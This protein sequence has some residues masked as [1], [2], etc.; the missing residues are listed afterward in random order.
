M[1]RTGSR[2]LAGLTLI[3]DAGK[4]SVAVAVGG[5]FAGSQMAA[6]AGLL[7]GCR[8][9]F[10]DLAEICWWQGRRHQSCCVCNAGSAAWRA[11]Y[12][13]VDCYRFVIALF[14]ACRALRRA[15]GDDWQLFFCWMMSSPRSLFLR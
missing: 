14:I 4:G 5:H 1:L 3:F 13:G 10:S 8:S 15:C 7:V 11:V 2:K 12:S 9:L 6:V